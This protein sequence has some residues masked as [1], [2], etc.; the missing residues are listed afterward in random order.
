VKPYE[1]IDPNGDDILANRRYPGDP[2]A[3]ALATPSR[4]CPP[5]A[6][7]SDQRAELVL[8][9]RSGFLFGLGLLT[10]SALVS[11]LCILV[12]SML[13]VRLWILE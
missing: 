1:L 11:A 6:P 3:P 10:A 2:V 8:T 9:F 7:R 4:P 12:L 13:G 5:A